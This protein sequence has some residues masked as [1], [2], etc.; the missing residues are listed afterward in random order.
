[1]D[2]QVPSAKSDTC[3]D[4][5]AGFGP[6]KPCKHVHAVTVQYCKKGPEKGIWLPGNT[7]GLEDTRRARSEEAGTE[8]ATCETI[9]QNTAYQKTHKSNING[10]RFEKNLI[11]YQTLFNLKS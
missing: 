5:I 3:P 10:N 4:Q 11:R 7:E 2:P 1:M 6:S 9:Y 8:N